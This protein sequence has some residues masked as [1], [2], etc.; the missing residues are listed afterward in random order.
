MFRNLKKKKNRVKVTVNMCFREVEKTQVCREN[1][2]M[3][4]QELTAGGEVPG[5]I[6][7]SPPPG[8]AGGGRK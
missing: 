8:R 1:R 4:R 2:L 7:L 3:S 5:A 6:V